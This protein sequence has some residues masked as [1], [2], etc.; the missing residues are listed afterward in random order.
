MK[1]KLN[2]LKLVTLTFLT[3]LLVLSSCQSDFDQKTKELNNV[4]IS[5]KKFEDLIG[6]P[7]F[8]KAIADVK[9]SKTS[10]TNSMRGNTIMENQ[11]NFTIENQT[12][13]VLE[14]TDIT[15]YT[16][17]ITRDSIVDNV[18]ENLVVQVDTQNK[19][20]AYIIK[21]T[22]NT[23]IDENFDMKFFSGT[24][25]I[26]SI[27]YNANIAAKLMAEEG[28]T[29]LTSWYCY[30][31]GHHATSQDCTMGYATTQIICPPV[32]LTGGGSGT[33]G[34]GSGSAGEVSTTATVV[35]APVVKN[36]IN[37]CILLK[38]MKSDPTF[39]GKMGNLIGATQWSFE[40]AFT[41]Y[42][43]ETPT[44]SNINKFVYQE[45]VG[46]AN[47]PSVNYNGNTT[48][49]GFIH[50]HYAGLLSI[51]SP[52]DLA[53]IYSKMKYPEIS[54]AFFAGVVTASGTAYIMQIEDRA[55]FIAFGDQFLSTED[56]IKKF[57]RDIY[58]KKY[59]INMNNSK[60]ANEE[61]FLKM[62]QK[63]NVGINIAAY[64]FNPTASGNQNL[65]NNWT[66]KKYNPTTNNVEPQN[67]N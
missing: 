61:G 60:E 5:H 49:Q 9:K 63:M 37:P 25:T 39:R 47:N 1:Q 35:T 15:S 38:M 11:Y 57:D 55:A 17:F 34:G 16:L 23:K 36:T 7:K 20:Q 22:N 19:T 44:K 26:T 6:Q 4:K 40:K 42:E 66:P 31:P 24:K 2:K 43:N 50:S 12:V 52:T 33:T 59:G 29:A 53:D 46:N 45:F 27:I 64:Y 32:S 3:L 21:Y 30:G 48:M 51:F 18:I 14:N 13:N 56:K 67:C 65:F 62:M 28:C 58:Q 41:V 10:N 54:D 8:S